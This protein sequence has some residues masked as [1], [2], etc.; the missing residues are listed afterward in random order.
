MKKKLNAAELIS[1]SS[2]LFGLFFGAGNL[3]FPAYM[4][5]AAGRSVFSALAGFL[6]TGVGLPL[7][8]VMALSVTRSDGVLTLGKRVGKGYSYFFTVALY[9]TIGPLFAI[10][11]CFTVP[12]ETGVAPLVGEGVSPRLALFLFTLFF[13]SV[14]LWFSLR[15]GNILTWVGKFLNPVFLTVFGVLLIAALINP[16][17]AT[18]AVEPQADYASSP[19]VKGFLEGY[20]TMDALAGFAFG[21]VV[22]RVINSLGIED[23]NAVA[24]NTARAGVFACL[25]MAAI[26]TAT[27][28]VGAQSRGGLE[29]AANGGAALSQ[30]SRHYFPG[31]GSVLFMLVVFFACLKTA[32]GLITSCSQAFEQMFPSVS[33]N[34]WAVLFSVVSFGVAN[35]GLTAIIK[36]A[37]PVLMMLYPL[38]MVLMILALS[39]RRLGLDGRSYRI[40]VGVTLIF[41]VGDFIAAL[42][43]SVTEA[44]HLGWIPALLGKTLPLY[45]QGLGWLTPAAAAFIAALIVRA[46]C[47]RCKAA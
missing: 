24:A 21:I 40:V 31:F 45:N 14:M 12:F 13:F 44:L 23:P 27:A 47:G 5:Q 22:I 41:A 28:L 19:F 2:M 36:L 4:G 42:P 34:K 16:M 33:Y 32:I 39:E 10:P 11:R 46:L 8:T 29:L 3:I 37:I 1:V 26:Y 18:G 6:V 7:L 20:N 15:P 43:A 35:F 25:L 30:I 9:L 38:C 17:G